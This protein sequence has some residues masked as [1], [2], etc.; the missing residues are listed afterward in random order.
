M[1][2]SLPKVLFI[3]KYRQYYGGQ[4]STLKESGLL[5]SAQFVCDML[6]KENFPAILEQVIDNNEIDKVVTKHKPNIVII[7]ALWV[8]PE[9]FEVLQKLHPNVKWIIRLHSEIPFLANEGIA[10]SWIPK[11]LQ[12]K[13][14]FLSANSYKT[15]KDL[16]KY[17]ISL[18]PSFTK[19]MVFLPNYYPVNNKT[20]PAE[21]FWD[22]GEVIDVGCFGAIRPLK[23]QLI[24]AIAAVQ[25]AEEKGLICRFHIN[26]TRI[27]GKG[28]NVLK[29]IRSF[30]DS[31]N[32]KHLLIEHPWMTRKK[33]LEVVKQMDIGLQMS[34][35]E[36]FNIVSADFVAEDIPIVTSDEVDWMPSFFTANTTDTRSIINAMNRVLFYDRHFIWLDWQRLALRRYVNKSKH[37]WKNNL[38]HI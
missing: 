9:K 33:F 37:I 15:H 26:S 11:Y 29:N 28:D 13:N 4:Y 3:L 14:V 16:I 8:V 12:Y 10:F 35:S 23:N 6:V 5:N 34:F 22:E 31:F 27:E 18:D 19:K 24:Q 21:L 30:F 36:T 38:L 20:T 7:E 32:G 17:T 1:S 25:F 2:S